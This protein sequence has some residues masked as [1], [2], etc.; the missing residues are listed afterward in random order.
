MAN[1]LS[2]R[3]ERGRLI[4]WNDEVIGEGAMKSV[5]FSPDRSYVVQFMKVRPA[6]DS[7]QRLREICVAK[8]D[9]LVTPD[10]IGQ[11]WEK[12]FCWP[13]DIIDHN[14][15][16]GLVAPAYDS[17]FFFSYGARD[18]GGKKLSLK[19]KEKHG[20]WFATGWHRSMLDPRE[21]GDFRTLLRVCMLLARGVRK[22]HLMGLAHSDLSYKNVLVDPS[23]G[24]SAIIDVDGL[25]VPGKIPPQVQGTPDFIAPEVVATAHL[26][27]AA[28]KLPNDRTDRHALAVLIYMYLLKRH[29]LRGGRNLGEAEEDERLQMGDRALWIEDP[30]DRSN[31]PDLR[32]PDEKEENKR[33]LDVEA[34][35][36][37]A[38]GP[39][40]APLVSRAFRVGLK[41]PEARPR[42]DDW[43]DA[44]V[45]SGDLLM[46]CANPNCSEKWFMLNMQGIDGPA[47]GPAPQ[48]LKVQVCP[49]CKTKSSVDT[50]FLNF[51]SYRRVEGVG[52]Y[53]LDGRKLVIFNGQE[54]M[55]WHMSAKA[56]FTPNERLTNEMRRRVGV[57]QFHQNAWYLR[58]ERMPNLMVVESGKNRLVPP[59]QSVILSD[60]MQLQLDSPTNDGRMATVQITGIRPGA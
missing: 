46:P 55:L 56:E 5:Y 3:S 44:L 9:A 41:T 7:I 40:L 52:T 47:N 19:G 22:M 11:Y 26:Q 29:P 39:F 49:F 31:R 51:Y 4:E 14:D 35:P 28:Q 53:L 25:V 37:T 1:R 23:T 21:L 27:G 36:Y 17:T 8:R 10:P 43:E 2:A 6:A 12:L 30:D 57:F 13:Y 42:A 15:R 60:A 34:L 20:K 50:P 32:D 38:L 58:N 54:L 45:R 48:P 59:G 24:S 33:W 18:E 16:I